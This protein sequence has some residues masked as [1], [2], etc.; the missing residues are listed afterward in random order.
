MANGLARH[1]PSSGSHGHSHGGG[2][3]GWL[4]AIFHLHGHKH[5]EHD[6]SGDPA[7][8]TREGIRTIWIALGALALT[9]VLQF[10]IVAVSGSVALLADTVHNFGD[11]LNSIPLLIAFYLA[12]RVATRRYTYGFGRAEDVAGI[13]IVLSIV[14]SAGYILWESFGKLLDPE[15]IARLPWV[16][17]A[18]VIGFLGNEAVALFQ[19]RTGNRIGSAS[20]VADGLHARIDGLTS[21]VVLVAVAGSALGFPIVDPIVGL[22][23]GVAIL[24][25]ARDATLRVWHRLMDAVDPQV[26]DQIEQYASEVSGVE[27]IAS[28]RVRWLGH[29]LQSEIGIALAEGRTLAEGQ[30]IV[31]NVKRVLHEHIRHLS[32]V[33]VEIVAI[34][35]AGPE[36]A[37]PATRTTAL[38]ILPP[39]YQDPNTRVSAAPMGAAAL[40]YDEQG[41]VAWDEMW[42]G[43]CELA[44]AGGAP[45][46]GTL[47]EP[48]HEAAI[49]ANLEQYEWVLKELE[50]GIAQVTK[51]P[52]RR[53]P[54]P[55]WIGLECTGEDMALWLLRAIVVENV[56]VR[57]EDNVL[58]F[59]AGP[60]F[61]LEREIRN[62]VTVV[63]KTTH[64]WQEHI[65]GLAASTR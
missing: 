39:R 38:G 52:V 15:P 58:W 6:L 41:D 7:F 4:A 23:I 28:I 45:H 51:L 63:A 11:M 35:A 1:N 40:H 26:V 17:A 27:E 64:Y 33:T 49:A 29:E 14:F 37:V 56:T 43:Y 16:A 31:S 2:P 9:T 12:R 42:T 30:A 54:V 24:F 22:L 48:V 19:I 61:R 44:L 53:S 65:A 55:G 21:L 3:L 50:R 36:A 13:V 59:P 46:R 18:A 25:I 60:H 5:P 62:V 57:R 47:L 32:L 34:D 10:V 20:L 8:G